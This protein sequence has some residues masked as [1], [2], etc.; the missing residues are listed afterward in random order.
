MKTNKQKVK[1]LVKDMLIES[2]KKALKSID[3]VLNSGCID[4]DSWDQKNAPMVLPKTILTAILEDEA[5]QYT[6]RGTS[7]EKQIKKEVKNI[8]YFL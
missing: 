6:A 1:E 2:H 3:K 8:Q 7:Y 4:I 5:R